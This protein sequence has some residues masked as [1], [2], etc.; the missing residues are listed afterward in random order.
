VFVNLLSNAIKYSH[1]EG[2]ITVS[3]ICDA[4]RASVSV[5]DN[6]I[7]LDASVVDRIFDLFV[8]GQTSLDR[9]RGGLGIGLSLARRLTELHGGSVHARSDGPGQGSEFI[10]SL[11]ATQAVPMPEARAEGLAGTTPT[12][13]NARVLVVDDN[14]DAASALGLLLESAGFSVF[15][16]HDGEVALRR[17]AETRPDVVLMDLGLPILDGYQVA[18]ALRNQ[19][20]GRDLTLVAVSGYGP[21]QDYGR[22]SSAGFDH[23]LVKPVDCVALLHLLMEDIGTRRQRSGRRLSSPRRDR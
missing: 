7:G 22:A 12:T 10:V 23:P 8:Q 4:E 1:D 3:A 17:A 6:G 21:G 11:P 16:A 19:P 5:R 18:A 2:I 13:P 20:G 15:L 14:V 9:A